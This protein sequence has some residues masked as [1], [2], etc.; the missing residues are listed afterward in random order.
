MTHN[1]GSGY[2]DSIGNESSCERMAASSDRHRAKVDGQDV[3]SRFCA[4]E[5][6][7]SKLTDKTIGAGTFDNLSKKSDGGTA[8]ERANKN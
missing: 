7:S 4:T 6:G 1:D 3:K 2:A 8:A 5:N